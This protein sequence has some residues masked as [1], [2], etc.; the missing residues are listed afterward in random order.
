M[1]HIHDYDV[2][3]YD[4]DNDGVWFCY[5]ISTSIFSNFEHTLYSNTN[6][7]THELD[8]IFLQSK[9]DRGVKSAQ[10]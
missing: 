7:K 2:D 3:D 6:G 5:K 4:N 1:E 10:T 8:G 9:T